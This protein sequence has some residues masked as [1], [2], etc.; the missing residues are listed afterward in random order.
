MVLK[1]CIKYHWIQN[2]K[3][4]HNVIPSEGEKLLLMSEAREVLL[5]Q[6]T[7]NNSPRKL[8]RIPLDA[9]NGCSKSEYS[10]Y[11]INQRVQLVASN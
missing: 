3:I 8:Q 1:N 9:D 5:N 7:F 2:K 11:S 10:L 4:Q 6:Q